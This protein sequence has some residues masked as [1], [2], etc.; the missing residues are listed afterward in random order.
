MVTKG[1]QPA[2]I[3]WSGRAQI[4]KARVPSAAASG[5]QRTVNIPQTRRNVPTAGR[6]NDRMAYHQSTVGLNRP[7]F[8]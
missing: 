4:D 6:D 7:P 2:L 5:P 8:G 1:K 3:A